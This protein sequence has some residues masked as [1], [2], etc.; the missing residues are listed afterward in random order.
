[1]IGKCGPK[2]LENPLHHG[3]ERFSSK[4]AMF[5]VIGL[6]VVPQTSKLPRTQPVDGTSKTSRVTIR[7]PVPVVS[8]PLL[9]EGE[10]LAK[11]CD[12]LYGLFCSDEVGEIG[13]PRSFDGRAPVLGFRH[14][15]LIAEFWS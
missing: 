15:S 12:E 14:Q 9:P 8:V 2:P 5:P 1:V 11:V 3:G 4:A 13:E 10:K 6:G 7:A